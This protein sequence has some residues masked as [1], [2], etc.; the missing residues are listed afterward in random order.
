ML[1]AGLN[2]ASCLKIGGELSGA[3]CPGG[4]LSDI[5]IKK[6]LCLFQSEGPLIHLLHYEMCELLKSLMGCFLKSRVLSET[7][8]KLLQTV[9]YF[10]S[11]YCQTVKFTDRSG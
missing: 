10:K 9:K 7:K 5:P 1:S 2:R 4:E 6:L 3:S 11:D 8:G